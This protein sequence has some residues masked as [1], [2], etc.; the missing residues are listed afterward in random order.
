M[1]HLYLSVALSTQDHPAQTLVHFLSAPFP[2]YQKQCGPL[3]YL[4]RAPAKQ[5][6]VEGKVGVR[7]KG[8]EERW[9]PARPGYVG[10]TW[11]FVFR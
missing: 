7:G 8:E 9:P 6:E 10:T 1:L 11:H 4:A 3:G 5:M 2:F